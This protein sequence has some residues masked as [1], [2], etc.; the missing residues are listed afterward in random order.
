MQITMMDVTFLGSGCWQGIPAPFSDDPI[1]SNV[2]WGSKDF[3]LRTSLLI[4]TANGKSI[5][6]EATPDIKLQ[7]W[8]F[9]LK[10]PEA[11]LISHWH[12]DH[13]WG[14]LD[15]DWYASKNKL[16]VY[17][18]SVTREWYESRM[19]HI[20]VNFQTME[21]YMSFQIDNVLIT[22]IAV[23]HVEKT[24]GFLLEDITTGKKVA[25]LSDLHGIPEKTR[26]LINGIDTIITDATYLESDLTDDPT[27]FQ[28]EQLVPFLDSLNTKETILTNIGSYQG[29]THSDYQRKFPKYTI[30]YDGM[31]RE[32]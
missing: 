14:L 24:D 13:L 18:N 7:S 8:K 5:I 28:N 22:P 3:R 26:E 6:I 17:G 30:A 19:G 20:A 25:Y 12:W 1:S 15:L 23:N 21:S 9:K 29:L 11:I 31:N 16:D 10:K 27:H 32:Y 2:E 4:N